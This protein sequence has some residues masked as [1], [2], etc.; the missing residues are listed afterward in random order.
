[1][2]ELIR[3]QAYVETMHEFDRG[4]E[5]H[6]L[7]SDFSEPKVMGNL[8]FQGSSLRMNESCVKKNA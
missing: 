2:H 6:K 3:F 8:A 5:P 4:R 7:V 1:M